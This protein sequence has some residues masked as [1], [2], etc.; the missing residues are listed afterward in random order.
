LAGGVRPRSVG[1]AYG[2]SR[3]IPSGL[4][5]TRKSFRRIKNHKKELS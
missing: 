3:L 5:T 1:F 4:K 2:Y